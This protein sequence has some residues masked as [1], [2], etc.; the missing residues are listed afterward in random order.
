M[1]DGRAGDLDLRILQLFLSDLRGQSVKRLAGKRRGWQA[2][3]P[4][5]QRFQKG[6]QM[7]LGRRRTSSL[8]GHGEHH[9]TNRRTVSRFPQTTGLID[10]LNQVQL[11]GDPD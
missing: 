9:F 8:Y 7:A 6:R 1:L 11:L 10:E 4:R 3:Y 5:H 2:R